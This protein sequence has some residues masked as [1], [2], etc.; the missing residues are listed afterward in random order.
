MQEKLRLKKW[1]E[2]RRPWVTNVIKITA[3]ETT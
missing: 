3:E 1:E 2:S